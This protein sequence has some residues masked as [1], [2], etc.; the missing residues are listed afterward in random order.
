MFAFLIRRLGQAV[1]VMF[2]ISLLSFSIQDE[3]GDPLRELVGQSVSEE[4]RQQLRELKLFLYENLYYHPTV[5]AMTD[6]AE[7]VLRGLWAAFCADPARLP[8]AARERIGADGERRAIAD[9]LAGMTDRFALAERERLG[10]TA[11]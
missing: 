3:L 1:I 8:E 2:V 7:Q 9:Y 10:D 5:K 6:D 4:T 11:S